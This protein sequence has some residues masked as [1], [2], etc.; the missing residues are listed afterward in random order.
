MQGAALAMLTVGVLVTVLLWAFGIEYFL[1]FG[2]LAGLL[3][4][5]PYLGPVIAFIG[6]T[7]IALSQSTTKAIW[8]IAAYTF[9][10]G[11]EGNVIVPFFMSRE[12]ALP[13]VLTLFTIFAMGQ[14]FGLIGILLAPPTLAVLLVFVR[15]AYGR[16]TIRK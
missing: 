4:I 14:L 12:V 2:I 6:P 5:V 3:D 13:P 16:Q 11:V 10:Q 8:V 15:F 7:L 1:L 9:V